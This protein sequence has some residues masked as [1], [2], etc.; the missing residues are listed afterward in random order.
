MVDE[1]PH[2]KGVLRFECQ[3]EWKGDMSVTFPSGT[4]DVRQVGERKILKRLGRC[5]QQQKGLCAESLH[6]RSGGCSRVYWS[7]EYDGAVS[8]GQIRVPVHV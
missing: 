7:C 5:F 4:V 3:W 8:L 1:V 2:E 6:V